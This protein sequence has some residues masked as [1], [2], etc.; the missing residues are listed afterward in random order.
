MSFKA[1]NSSRQGAARQFSKS[2]HNKKIKEKRKRNTVVY[3][4]EMPQTTAKE[5]AEK[6][7]SSL[8]KLGSQVFA[9][10]PFSQY[11]DDWLINLRQVLLEFETNSS[12]NLDEQY[13]KQQSQFLQ[14]IDGKMAEKRLQETNLTD[15]AK[16]LFNINHLITN[17][18]KEYAEKNRVQ[19]NKRNIEVQKLNEK[20]RILEDQLANQQKI[21]ISFYKLKERR[22]STQASIQTTQ[23]L[24]TRKTELEVFLSNFSA[25]QEKLHDSYQKLKQE[26]SEK[27]DLLHK[28][29][30]KLE[31]DPSLEERK[32][33]CAALIENINN[34]L[35][36]TSR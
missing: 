16:E 36:R 13:K 7:I 15:E 26:L 20:I 28:E 9:L 35:K 10:S 5:T 8:S 11:F 25:E 34:L 6:T 4:D 22:A 21:K 3:I 27:S 1:Q 30:E 33:V 32:N 29:L 24:I 18:D 14:E 12:I 17:A 23:D 19:N 2:A 31:V